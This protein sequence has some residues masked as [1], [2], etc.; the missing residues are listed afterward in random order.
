[1]KRGEVI[2]QESNTGIIVSNWKDK[3][4]VRFLTTRHSPL[5][6]LT[7]KKNRKEPVSKPSDILLYNRHKQGIDIS[8]QLSSYF[9][10]LRKSIRWFHKVAFE[11][12]FG[13]AVVNALL[14]YTKQT[15]HKCQVSTFR[16]KLIIGILQ[17]QIQ[18]AHKNISPNRRHCIL[19]ET[20]VK[21]RLNGK[22]QKRCTMCYERMV[23]SHNRLHAQKVCKQ[24]TTYC[25]ICPEKPFLCI[26]CFQER[27]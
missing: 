2:S 21:T 24:V 23:K 19:K 18:N 16:E 9:T 6:V 22:L 14:L 3:K 1:M 25:S 12:L 8:N 20:D 7:C 27:H 17:S 11:L 10:V 26:Q 4:N 15:K 5:I 13:T